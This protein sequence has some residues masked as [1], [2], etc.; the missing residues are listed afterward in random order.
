[1]SF[2]SSCRGGGTIASGVT[3]M[4]AWHERCGP[5]AVRNAAAG[6]LKA[7]W[8]QQTIES[9]PFEK[10]IVVACE[11][12]H[13]VEERSRR[14]WRNF[15]LLGRPC[16]MCRKLEATEVFLIPRLQVLVLNSAW[17]KI[18]GFTDVV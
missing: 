2:E 15:Y 11:P 1:M 14:G 9:G 16:K 10:L 4:D 12:R 6:S 5:Q 18:V 7:S 13:L 8:K 17:L 3:S